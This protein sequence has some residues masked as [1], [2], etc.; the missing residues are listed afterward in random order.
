ML[1]LK[2]CKKRTVVKLLSVT[3]VGVFLGAEV[4]YPE[5]S[6]R[7]VMSFVKNHSGLYNNNRIKNGIDYGWIRQ[8]D[9]TAIDI[10]DCSDKFMAMEVAICLLWRLKSESLPAVGKIKKEDEIKIKAMFS[11]EFSK[12]IRQGKSITLKKIKR[13]WYVSYGNVHLIIEK[14][15]IK[16]V[17]RVPNKKTKIIF[18]ITQRSIDEKNNVQKFINYLLNFDI[19]RNLKYIGGFAIAF[20]TGDHT[21]YFRKDD[22][23]AHINP[24]EF[25]FFYNAI[26]EL[27][28]SPNIFMD[29][30]KQGYSR[31]YMDVHSQKIEW[32]VKKISRILLVKVNEI[33]TDK[34]TLGQKSY[35]DDNRKAYRATIFGLGCVF[36]NEMLHISKL[37]YVEIDE[38]GSLVIDENLKQ[39]GNIGENI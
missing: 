20:E 17:E 11:D 32:L 12:H 38:K 7:P 28:N 14:D 15:A 9:V 23:V 29:M 8:D 37:F 19:T 33:P 1:D 34:L 3:M 26:K 35:L 10:I 13:K 18:N 5:V 27:K 39:Q 31:I 2:P 6:L 4:A 25:R 24:V 22:L 16:S 36:Q 30:R 21:G